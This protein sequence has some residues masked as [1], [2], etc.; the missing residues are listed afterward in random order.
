MI[1]IDFGYI[2]NTPH[3]TF[4]PIGY[5]K[6]VFYFCI[7]QIMYSFVVTNICTNMNERER[8]LAIKGGD[9]QAFIDLYNV[10]F[11]TL[12]DCTSLQLLMQRKL[13]RMCL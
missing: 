13:F 3:I 10:R 2:L 1:V 6:N 5:K 9:H 8:V 12:A 11:M 7:F 4:T